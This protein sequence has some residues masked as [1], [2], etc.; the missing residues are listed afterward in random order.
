MT[1]KEKRKPTIETV[2]KL[3][4]ALNVDPAELLK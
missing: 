2:V 3:A 1:L 4:K